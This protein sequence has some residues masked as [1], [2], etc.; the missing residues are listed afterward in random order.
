M[1]NQ[2]KEKFGV[3]KSNAPKESYASSASLESMSDQAGRSPQH[4]KAAIAAPSPPPSQLAPK[5]SESSLSND[6]SSSMSNN[7]N[8]SPSASATLSP[9]KAKAFEI[10]K[11]GYPA[12]SWID[13]QKNLLKGKYADA[14]QLGE[15]ANSMRSEISKSS[16]RKKER[17]RLMFLLLYNRTNEGD[18]GF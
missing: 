11:A 5:R 18:A 6:P 2:Y 7:T 3:I 17:D 4:R 16:E 1:I 12:G 13:G 9:E 15:R 14:K 10:F 8:Y